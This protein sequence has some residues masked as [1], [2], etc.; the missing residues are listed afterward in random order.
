MAFLHPDKIVGVTQAIQ[1]RPKRPVRSIENRAIS[2]ANQRGI[3]IGPARPVR[4]QPGISPAKPVA[5]P[6]ISPAKPVRD[7][8]SIGK[9]KPAPKKELPGI[10]ENLAFE[11]RDAHWANHLDRLARRV[12]KAVQSR[13]PQPKPQ[14]QAPGIVLQLG[15]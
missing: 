12:D 13:N 6:G 9:S 2:A 1:A 3:G 14:P 4:P 10:I 5:K 8:P 7:Q 11:M 15:R